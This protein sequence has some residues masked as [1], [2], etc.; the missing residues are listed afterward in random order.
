MI[1]NILLNKKIAIIGGGPVGLTAARLLQIKGASV[2]VYERDLHETYRLLGG[3]LDIHKDTGQHALAKAGLLT[4]FFSLAR[5]TGNRITD[6]EGNIIMDMMPDEE[7]YFDAPEVDRPDFRNLL[8]DNLQENTVIWN[9]FVK[10]VIKDGAGYDILFAD[11][12]TVY[13]DLVIIAD[14]TMSR[15]RQYVTTDLPRYT[16]TYFIQGEVE[17]PAT[18]SP[19]IFRLANNGNLG[20]RDS[21]KRIFLHTKGN[22]HLSY[23]VTLTKPEGWLEEEKLDLN[24]PAE[25]KAY[26]IN[27]FKDWS[28]I[29]KE[30][31]RAT[32][33]FKGIPIKILALDQPWP[34][35][36]NIT[37][38]GD[39]AHVMPP[40]GG[41][42]VNLGLLDSLTLSNNLTE[43][44]FPDIQSAV[45]DYEQQMFAYVKP[46]QHEALIPTQERS[47]PGDDHANLEKVKEIF[48]SRGQRERKN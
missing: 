28:E 7:S 19:G 16:G 18:R 10:E 2:N 45:D 20:A 8:L 41:Q 29:Y 24:N 9:S 43:G 38:I 3:S 39:A 15:A 22:G 30:L 27:F 13:A 25:V 32:E 37:I 34:D 12:R 33:E 36:E 35:H 23:Y 26:L 47:G 40:F 11:G 21:G 5:P 48:S 31:F 44:E 6:K 17:S 1:R 46:I 42:G 4:G 14:G